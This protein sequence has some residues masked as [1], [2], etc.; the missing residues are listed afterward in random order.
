MKQVPLGELI[1]ITQGF[2]FDSTLFGDSGDLPLVRIRDVVPGRSTTFLR[3]GCDP[4]YLVGDGDILIGMDGEFNR[5]RWQ[6]GTA[7]LN[8][9]VCRVKPINGH[10][11]EAYLFHL[12]PAELKRIEDETPFVTVKHLSAR[13]LRS[14]LIP[15]PPLEDQRRIAAILDEADALRAK[16]RAALAQLDEMARAIF[17]EM[18]GDLS[19]NSKGWPS[20]SINDA[21]ELIVD[22]VNRTAP[23]AEAPTDFKMIRTTNVRNGTVQLENVRY[24]SEETFQ[25][26]NRRATPR[27]GD[28][29][30][31]REAPVG[32]AGII[33]TD[34]NVFL[35]Q[36]LMLYRPLSTRMSAEFLLRS[37][38]DP[39]CKEQFDAQGSGST[40]KHLPLPACRSFKLR[41]P[42]F[43]LQKVYSKRMRE[44]KAQQDRA[45]RCR[46]NLDSLFASL[47]HR[48]FR[49]E[50]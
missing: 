34:D 29:I 22:C 11:D 42:P 1:E 7:A 26:W 32:E 30:L 9:R 15:L 20:V 16:R 45:A 19:S 18:F 24:V 3:G 14:A 40:V 37:F 12:L 2:A 27:K 35:G 10:L 36:R 4:R 25:R 5:A 46:S 50:L 43:E 8:Q 6:G 17:V 23:L 48:A 31:T 28:V 41:L 39:F 44:L 38:M 49:G 21:C 33:E 47:Q 13:Q